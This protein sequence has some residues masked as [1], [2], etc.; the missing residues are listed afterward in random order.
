MTIFS[1]QRRATAMKWRN[2]QRL[3]AL[4]SSIRIMTRVNSASNTRGG[5]KWN[6]GPISRRSS[7][8][9]SALSGQAMQ[10]PATNPWA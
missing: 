8:A 2:S 7:A 1:P 5:A 10:N 3:N 6:V 9:V 4:A